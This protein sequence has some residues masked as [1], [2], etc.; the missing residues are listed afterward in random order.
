MSS[1][2]FRVAAMKAVIV[3]TFG[4]FFSGLDVPSMAAAE[5]NAEYGDAYGFRFNHGVAVDIDKTVVKALKGTPPEH[6]RVMQGGV[7]D[8][9]F[10]E[11][12]AK[13]KSSWLSSPCG[14]FTSDGCRAG[15][16]GATGDP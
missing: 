3:F 4:T 7:T 1:S 14:D 13:V 9:K 2:L 12:V 8:Q 10:M 5:L 16:A 15:E 11:T 6:V